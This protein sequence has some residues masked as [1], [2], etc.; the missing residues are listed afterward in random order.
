MFSGGY[1]DVQGYIGIDE[2][3]CLCSSDKTYDICEAWFQIFLPNLDTFKC[4]IQSNLATAI[5]LC[6]GYL[7][8]GDRFLWNWLNHG[9]TLIETS[10]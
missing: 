9:Q 8:I 3:Y 7:A 10:I 2:I 5:L 6:S 4:V 1:I